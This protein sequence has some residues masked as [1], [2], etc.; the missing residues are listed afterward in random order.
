MLMAMIFA[1]ASLKSRLTNFFVQKIAVRSSYGFLALLIIMSTLVSVLSP[2]IVSAT[3]ATDMTVTQ[4]AQSWAY[5]NAARKCVRDSLGNRQLIDVTNFGNL[6]D[7]YWHDILE[8][9]NARSGHWWKDEFKIEASYLANVDNDGK[10][11]CNDILKSGMDLWGYGTDYMGLLCSFVPLRANGSSCGSGSGYFNNLGDHANDFDTVIKNKV[12]GG[13]PARVSPAE[14]YPIYKAVFTSPQGCQAKPSTIAPGQGNGDLIYRDIQIIDPT[15]GQPTTTTFEGLSHGTTKSVYTDDALSVNKQ[16][17]GYIADRINEYANAYKLALAS[18]DKKDTPPQTTTCTA[19]GCPAT[20]SSCSID[21]IGWIVCPVI[22][23][24]SQIVDAAYIFVSSLLVVQP[25]MTTGQTGDIYRAWTIMRNIANIFFIIGFVFVI[26][27]QVTSIGISNYG[28]KK[29]LPRLI[30]AAILVNASYWICSIAVDLSNVIGSSVRGLF[31]GVGA[32]MP[33]DVNKTKIGDTG[34]GWVGIAG[35]LL[36]GTALT[37]AALYIGLSAL[38]PA[39]LAALIAVIVVFLVLTLRQALIILLVVISPLA[40]VAILL[41]NTE[42]LFKKW[43]ELF[44]TM[45][46]MFPIIAALFGASS[47]ASKVVMNTASGDY[48]IVIQIMGALM[49]VLPLAITPLVMKTAGGLLNRF[50]GIVNNPNKGPVDR[51]R[52]G[53]T[54]LRERRKSIMDTRRLGRSAAVLGGEGALLGA[55]GTRRRR[56]AA[57]LAGSGASTALNQQLKNDNAK[58]SLAEAKQDY[59]VGRS[60]DQDYLETIAGPTG[61]VSKIKAAAIAAQ[62]N[63]TADAIK[64][65]KLSANIAPG[66]VTEMGRRF[67]EAMKSNNDIEARAMQDLMLTSGSP[68]ISE[69]RKRMTEVEDANNNQ[70]EAVMASNSMRTVRENMLNTH[71]ALKAAANDLTVQAAKGMKMSAASGSH[72][73]WQ[74]SDLDL[75]KQ[76]TSSINLAVTHIDIEQAKRIIGNEELASQLDPTARQ[77]IKDRSEGRI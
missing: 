48:K 14:L 24:V 1:L 51:L 65:V 8:E 29:I 64:N 71:G 7:G 2:I 23:F 44:Q 37:A 50:A 34:E 39:L 13:Q 36:A 72:D 58:K 5:L 56:T 6:S 18:S 63:E 67:A 28:I 3:A 35:F 12:Y 47:L 27:S 59:V 31:D 40:F 77:K 21:G 38:I 9:N 41:P 55:K 30:V 19:S 66:D 75:V 26:F 49:A 57:W 17:C 46:L 62:K 53:A 25:L 69:Y 60:G 68:G 32:Q 70:G 74:M 61:N 33:V 22:R 16:N 52:K 4:R 42:S 11:A 54:D 20:A 43:R 73:T 76:K 15:S 45:L 10:A